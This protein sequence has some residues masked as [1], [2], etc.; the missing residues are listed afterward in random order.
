MFPQKGKEGMGRARRKE[1]V[2][3]K[4]C[5]EKTKKGSRWPGP[6]GKTRRNTPKQ[7]C[8]RA[9]TK[10]RTETH[11]LH[12]VQTSWARVVYTNASKAFH[13]FLFLSR[14][15][16]RHLTQDIRLW[17]ALCKSI[18]K[19]KWVCLTYPLGNFLPISGQGMNFWDSDPGS[20]MLFLPPPRTAHP[21]SIYPLNPGAQTKPVNS[22]LK[23]KELVMSRL[24]GGSLWGRRLSPW[25]SEPLGLS[26]LVAKSR[27]TLL[28]LHGLQPNHFYLHS[29]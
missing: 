6:G 13:H 19:V 2:K 3:K 18:K 12:Y 17:P 23:R 21:I 14:E 11:L 8:A 24:D 5:M 28:W 4:C 15:K 22:S 29:G 10:L 25:F 7:L 1:P 27:P 20:K 9:L 26:C 16:T